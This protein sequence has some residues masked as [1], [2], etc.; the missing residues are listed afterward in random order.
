VRGYTQINLD[1]I[2]VRKIGDQQT[3]HSEDTYFIAATDLKY[4]D[5]TKK[6]IEK[7][8]KESGFVDVVYGHYLKI[9]DDIHDRKL[10]KEEITRLTN[11]AI[12]QVDFF[13]TKKK[14]ILSGEMKLSKY[15]EFKREKTLF[16]PW[17]YTII[18]CSFIV[19]LVY[20]LVKNI[21]RLFKR[22]K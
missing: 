21:V 13:Y 2:V 20:S 15:G 16:P 7:E 17:V 14:D 5:V 1:Y 19:M 22:K 3:V 6:R 11:D 18:F 4:R 12:K 10:G 9:F 8:V